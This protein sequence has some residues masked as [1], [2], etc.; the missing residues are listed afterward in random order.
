MKNLTLLLLLTL[1]TYGSGFAQQGKTTKDT[2]GY[3]KLPVYPLKNITQPPVYN[4][5]VKKPAY[6]RRLN[7]DTSG[8]E[9]FPLYLIKLDGNPSYYY[10]AMPQL[11][12]IDQKNIKAMEILKGNEADK[13]FP[14][15]GKNGVIIITLNKD[16]K[17]LR[18]DELLNEYH[19]K[20]KYQML[21]IYL[22]SN[23]INHSPDM[24]FT[25]DKI[26]NISVA[27]EKG[28]DIKYISILTDNNSL[29]NIRGL[30]A[31]DNEMH[32]RGNSTKESR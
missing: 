17:L 7:K 28:T 8:F 23:L 16:V 20:K 2:S 15:S 31:P 24:V 6:A 25:A 1:P 30:Q 29:R 13:Q 10:H 26:K 14:E 27:K 9:R 18:V 19:I 5:A 4:N 21:P 22:D 32:I 3:A 12:L 11:G